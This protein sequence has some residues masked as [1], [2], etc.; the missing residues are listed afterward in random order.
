MNHFGNNGREYLRRLKQVQ[1][2]KGDEPLTQEEI[3]TLLSSVTDESIDKKFG[4]KRDRR[5]GCLITLAGTIIF[6]GIIIHFIAM[7][8]QP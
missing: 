1:K 6:W 3:D 2:K 7:T 4:I 5:L 8:Y